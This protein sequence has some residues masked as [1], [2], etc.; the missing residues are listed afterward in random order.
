MKKSILLCLLSATLFLSTFAQT[1]PPSRTRSDDSFTQVDNYVTGLKRLGIPTATSDVLVGTATSANT[2]K[3]LWRSDLQKLR[4]YNPANSTW[5]DAI[6]AITN[7]YSTSPTIG[8]ALVSSQNNIDNINVSGVFYS[9]T[10]GAGTR[11]TGAGNGYV[12]SNYI[13]PNNG[14]FF[15]QYQVAG[16]GDTWYYRSK[17]NGTLLAWR[18]V[19]SR[20]WAKDSLVTLNTVQTIT[21]NKTINANLAVNSSA[22]DNGNALPVTSFIRQSPST[23]LISGAYQIGIEDTNNGQRSGIVFGDG[24]NRNELGVFTENID[25]SNREVSG[26]V[27]EKD[28]GFGMS[29]NN[30]ANKLDWGQQL[31]PN[32]QGL[33][34]PMDMSL[35]FVYQGTGNILLGSDDGTGGHFQMTKSL[36]SLSNGTGKIELTATQSTVGGRPINYDQDRR[37]AFT[38]L[39]LVDKGYVDNIGGFGLS[40]NATTNKI[41]WGITEGPVHGISIPSNEILAFIA[42]QGAILQFTTPSGVD[43]AYFTAGPANYTAGF[44]AGGT[45]KNFNINATQAQFID[46]ISSKGLEYGANYSANY[47][48]R[49]LVDKEYVDSKTAILS[50]STTQTN[51]T[52]NSAYPD[53]PLNPI[54]KTVVQPAANKCFIKVTA[55]T[56]VSFNTTAL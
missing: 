55:S 17:V 7:F 3:L 30:A 50:G 53:G 10:G 48:L 20:E 11:P 4:V 54:G 40:Y 21:A 6:P 46:N 1:T 37:S 51:A 2:G 16:G 38:D 52:L 56:W 24:N 41:D 35:R 43:G 25:G 27:F 13:A 31:A 34:V 14:Y 45:F 8:G 18:Q 12:T 49:S 39:S 23:A 36:A 32:T 47:T 44:K 42:Q 29:W 19:A 5:Y 15:Q 22:M 28:A 33:V 9:T 26:F